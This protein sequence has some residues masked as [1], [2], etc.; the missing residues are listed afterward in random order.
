MK[1]ILSFLGVNKPE[2]LMGKSIKISFFHSGD[3]VFYNFLF[4][5]ASY[6]LDKNELAFPPIL[7][8]QGLRKIQ[9]S[10]FSDNNFHITITNNNAKQSQEAYF[11]SGIKIKSDG[12][13]KGKVQLI[14]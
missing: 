8:A 1:K 2:Q 12:I 7:F 13:S 5:V 3:D 14:K 11:Y 9:L 6:S 10:I 4:T